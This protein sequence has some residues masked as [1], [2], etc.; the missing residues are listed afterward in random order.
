[1]LTYQ[2]CVAL[3]GLTEDEIAAVA[4]H[5]HCPSIIALELGN[6][7]LRQPD[8]TARISAYIQDD[9]LR[10]HARC[11]YAQSSKLKFVLRHFL[12]THPEPAPAG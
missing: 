11:D 5:E 9:I 7:L 10:A 3:S 1:M 4:E 6:Y 12:E 8:G 2:D